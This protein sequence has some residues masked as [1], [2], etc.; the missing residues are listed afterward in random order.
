MVPGAKH[1]P[2]DDVAQ[3][4]TG[5]DALASLDEITAAPRNNPRR[6]KEMT[7]QGGDSAPIGSPRTSVLIW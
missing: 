6:F 4:A 1:E 2:G 7:G 5:T 3:G